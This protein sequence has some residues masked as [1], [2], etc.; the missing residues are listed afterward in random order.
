MTFSLLKSYG[1]LHLFDW[2]FCTLLTAGLSVNILS[3]FELNNSV[4]DNLP[5]MILLAAVLQLFCFLGLYSR[6]A[7]II[8]SGVFVT[9]LVVVIAYARTSD[10]FGDDEGFS[11][12]ITAIVLILVSLA[13]AL[14]SVTRG[15]IL[16]FLAAGTVISASAAFLQFPVMKSGFFLFLTA[17]V[18]LFL[19]RVY[20]VTRRNTTGGNARSQRFEY[21]FVLQ[22]IGLVMAGL[23]LASSVFLLIIKPLDPPTDEL[24]LIEKLE[25]RRIIERSGIKTVYT[26]PNFA[27]RSQNETDSSLTG[28]EPE[29]TDDP[30]KLSQDSDM[31][32]EEQDEGKSKENPEGAHAIHYDLNRHIWWIFTALV[33]LAI[34]LPFLLRELLRRKWYAD[35][36]QLDRESQAANL[37]LYYLRLFEKIGIPRGNDITLREYAARQVRSIEPYDVPE[38]DFGDL[39]D[40]YVKVSYGRHELTEKEVERYHTYYQGIRGRIRR[41][42]GIFRFLLLY[43][44]I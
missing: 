5:V 42:T 13:T 36:L 38:T 35:L 18:L 40:L 21:Q 12:Q 29:A 20:S 14:L 43:F 39:T 23:L 34:C 24:K 2:V 3:G 31:L 27:L 28:N 16:V 8:L 26:F 33:L 11:T 10:I 19:Y 37:Y 17:A 15:G 1:R 41:E 30:D 4:S 44:T 25:Q 32:D 7:L 6:R 9:A 22:M